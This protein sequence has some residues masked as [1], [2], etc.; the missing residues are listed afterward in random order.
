[1]TWLRDLWTAA[2]NLTPEQRSRSVRIASI[3]AALLVVLVFLLGGHAAS[4]TEPSDSALWEVAIMARLVLG[5][6][7]AAL[8]LWVLSVA[9]ALA[10]FQAVD[11]SSLG[12]RLWMWTDEQDPVKDAKKA[13][14]ARVLCAL[15][16]AAAWVFGS[17]LR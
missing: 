8:A 1:M 3:T 17:A 6:T 7:V 14:A 9:A 4:K 5:R 15:I 13:N 16:L 11:N 2:Y 12:K 10:A